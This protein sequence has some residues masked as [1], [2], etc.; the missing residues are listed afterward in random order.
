MDNVHNYYEGVIKMQAIMETLFDAFYLVSVITLGAIMILK[1]GNNKQYKLFGFMAV[2]LGAGD[3]FHLIPRS[4]ALFTTGLEANAA[5]LGIGKFITSITMTIF[6]VILYHIWRQRYNIEGRKKLTFSI[7]AL[8]I[9]RIGLCL[10]PQ[11]DWLNFNS[12]VLWGI[13]RNIPFLFMGII[14][15]DI[16]YFEAKK[17]ADNNFRYMWLAIVLSFAFYIPVVLWAN[18]IPLIGILM[19]P[20]TIAYLWV[21][22]MGY[23]EFQLNQ[24]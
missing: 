8:S 6:Y 3:A 4:Y 5:A 9:I 24:K 14:I 19:I 23:K 2:L 17:H 13:Y 15:I 18:T 10:F 1:S 7:Y 22:I 16:F 12:P 11:N 20:K 21:V